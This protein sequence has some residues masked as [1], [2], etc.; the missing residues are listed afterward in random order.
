VTDALYDAGYGSSSTLYEQAA[1][2]LGMTPAH[3]KSGADQLAISYTT[4]R[5]PLG[6]LL[7]ANTT[8]GVCAVSLGDTPQELVGWLEAEFPRAEITEDSKDS[9]SYAAQVLSYLRGEQPHCDLPVDVQATAFQ[10]MVWQELRRI[11]YGAIRSYSEI[12]EA[13]GQPSAVR[14]VARA[15]A[16]NPVSLVVP[17]HRVVRKTGNLGGYRWGLQRKRALLELEKGKVPKSKP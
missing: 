7:I 17:C 13:I 12:A 15:C 4:T 2:R 1:D 6:W 11:P 9:Q 14:A 10:R 5:C 3:Y 16:T 8:K